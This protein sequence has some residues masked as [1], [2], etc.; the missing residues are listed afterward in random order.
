MLYKMQ[1]VDS[2][3]VKWDSNRLELAVGFQCNNCT[4][5]VVVNAVSQELCPIQVIRW[6]VWTSFAILEI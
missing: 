6:N 5:G 4:Q 3:K 1:E 2:Q